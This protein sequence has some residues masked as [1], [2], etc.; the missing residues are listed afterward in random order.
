MAVSLD[1]KD[2]CPGP[3]KTLASVVLYD[4][5]ALS[6]RAAGRLDR[7]LRPYFI[8]RG[9]RPPPIELQLVRGRR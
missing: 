5:A 4:Q 9:E 8:A 2:V 6:V 3:V 7:E 1:L